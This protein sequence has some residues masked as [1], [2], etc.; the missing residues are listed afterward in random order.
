MAD[1]A[2]SNGGIGYDIEFVRNARGKR[3][4]R[5]VRGPDAIAQ[6]VQMTFRTFLGESRYNRV[7][8]IPWQQVIFQPGMTDTAVIVVLERFFLTIP[9]VLDV[10]SI[11]LSRDYETRKATGSATIRVEATAGATTAVVPLELVLP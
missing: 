9:G 7:A 8:G 11:D 6:L 1:F 5:I 4:F 3:D 10:L 2:L